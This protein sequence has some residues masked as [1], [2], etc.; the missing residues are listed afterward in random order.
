[1][2]QSPRFNLTLSKVLQFIVLVYQ[3]VAVLAF[4]VAIIFAIQWLQQPF[5]GAF[6]EPTMVMN[7]AV[8]NGPSDSWPLYNQGATHGDQLRS[9]AGEE[10]HNVTELGQVLS[11]YFPGETIPVVMRS[12]DGQ[13]TTYNVELHPFPAKDRNSYLIIPSI[14]SI[15]FFAL[16]FWIFG[17]R[18]NEPAGRAFSIFASS[19]AIVA[20]TFFDLYTTHQFSY[21]WA[22]A[23]PMA[24]GATWW[25]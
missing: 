25:T 18:R 8:P 12:V 4:I 17:L 14:V 24:G 5:L 23:L 22:F 6:F 15:A 13:E 7:Q 16:S 3:V 9:I 21:L 2:F 20:G 1:M 11:N 19:M 10:I